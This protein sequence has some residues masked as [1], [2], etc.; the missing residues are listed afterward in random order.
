VDDDDIFLGKF[1]GF[2][3]SPQNISERESRHRKR[4]RD[5]QG[6]GSLH[7]RC[8]LLGFPFLRALGLTGQPVFVFTT[9]TRTS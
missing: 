7:I 5:D 1:L 3:H 2:V 8:R 6:L 9:A 4:G